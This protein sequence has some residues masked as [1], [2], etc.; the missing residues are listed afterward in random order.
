MGDSEVV[1]RLEPHCCRVCFG[2]ILSR[3]HSVA[4]MRIFRCAD[5]G[6][7]KEGHISHVL[8]A[9]GATLNARNA[10]IRCELNERPI[11]EFP[12]EICAKQS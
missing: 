1:W 11:P 7:E 3:T 6:L 8:C 9:C 4:G 12:F 2:R 5:C 10:G